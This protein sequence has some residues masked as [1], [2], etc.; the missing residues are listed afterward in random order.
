M[1]NDLNGVVAMGHTSRDD[2]K[3][4]LCTDDD[5]I[6]AALGLCALGRLDFNKSPQRAERDYNVKEDPPLNITLFAPKLSTGTANAIVVPI[7]QRPV[8]DGLIQDL[9]TV[10]SSFPTSMP[11]HIID[12]PDG[13]SM[14]DTLPKK[15]PQRARQRKAP[16]GGTPSR[17]NKMKPKDPKRDTSLSFEEMKRLMQVYGPIKAPRN[18][19]SE[20]NEWAVKPES[21]RRKFC[22]WFPDF[23]ERFVK[24]PGGWYM[25]KAAGH[26]HEM[27]YREAKQREIHYRAAKRK[28]DQEILVK[29][30]NGKH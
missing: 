5:A 22:R 27:N 12:K 21:V 23:S 1:E 26:Q 13:F 30:R 3:R 20:N 24:S 7:A 18:R 14:A 2:N 9:T 16:V 29:K 17:K 4:V 6:N 25:P 28:M 10:Y 8:N 11:P 15:K 19:A